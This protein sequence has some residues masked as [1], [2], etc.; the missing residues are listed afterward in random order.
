MIRKQVGDGKVLVGVSGGVDSTVVAALFHKAIG[1]RSTAV[2]IDHGLLRK[3][4]AKNCTNALK[5]GLGVN[6]HCYNE[7]KLFLSKLEG[8]VDPEKKREIIGNQFI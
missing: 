4:E 3:E 7:S 2:L 1:D 5:D 6:I 8:V